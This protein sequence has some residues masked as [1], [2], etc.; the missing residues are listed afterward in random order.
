VPTGESAKLAGL[1]DG[2]VAN[3]GATA[4][5]DS[6]SV[7]S[8]DPAQARGARWSVIDVSRFVM[9]RYAAG[10]AVVNVSVLL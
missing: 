2:A 6:A 3:A 10:G 8:R 1:A 4:V 9:A 7:A 5:A